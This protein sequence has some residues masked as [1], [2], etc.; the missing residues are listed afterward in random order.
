MIVGLFLKTTRA[1]LQNCQGRR[2]WPIRPA[3]WRRM[4]GGSM[5]RQWIRTAALDH[6]VHGG[7]RWVADAHAAG[8]R[9]AAAAPWP[10]PARFTEAALRCT[11][12]FAEG[13]G[14]M[15]GIRRE[16]CA[17]WLRKRGAGA[18][19]PRGG[20]AR[21]WR[22]ISDEV[23]RYAERESERANSASEFAMLLRT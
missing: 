13:R 12:G 4:R 5:A 16:R 7:P 8:G 3:T 22:G 19:G 23:T 17:R 10:M 18:A 21:W 14:A 1:F 2:G 11:G 9:T 20:A 6:R 15:R